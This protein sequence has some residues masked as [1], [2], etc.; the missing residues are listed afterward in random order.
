MP[1]GHNKTY[2]TRRPYTAND[3]GIRKWFII[4]S[5]T[6]IGTKASGNPGNNIKHIRNVSLDL[7]TK[8]SNMIAIGTYVDNAMKY[9]NAYRCAE[10]R[11][12]T[13]S[14][15]NTKAMNTTTPIEMRQLTTA[16][17][18]KRSNSLED[19]GINGSCQAIIM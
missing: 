16:H 12:S 15:Q 5:T 7:S 3:P 6:K 10:L 13:S 18:P 14:S 8:K 19:F 11:L 9:E 1:E 17:R 4:R 2:G